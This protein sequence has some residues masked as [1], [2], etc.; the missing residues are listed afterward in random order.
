MPLKKRSKK[1]SEHLILGGSLLIVLTAIAL[2]VDNFGAISNPTTEVV[3]GSSLFGT[4]TLEYIVLFCLSLFFAFLLGYIKS[5]TG[6]GKG[7]GRIRFREIRKIIELGGDKF[8]RFATLILL[9]LALL[10]LSRLSS[11]ILVFFIE[12]HISAQKKLSVLLLLILIPSIIFV[13]QPLRRI[14]E[15]IRELHGWIGITACFLPIFVLATVGISTLYTFEKISGPESSVHYLILT[16]TLV[17]FSGI[18]LHT[19]LRVKTQSLLYLGILSGIFLLLARVPGPLGDL[20]YFE[21]FPKL[22]AFA[23]N[24]WGYLPWIDLQLNHGLYHDFIRPVFGTLLFGDSI[25]AMQA[26][27]ASILFPLEVILVLYLTGKIL[28]ARFHTVY[29]FMVFIAFT[30]AVP[31]EGQNSW[32][33]IYSLPR[34]IPLLLCTL[35]LK[36]LLQDLKLVNYAFVSVSLALSTMWASE[37][38]IIWISV[39]ITLLYYTASTKKLNLAMVLKLMFSVILIPSLLIWIPLKSL[40]L[41]QGFLGDYEGLSSNLLQGALDF[42]FKAGLPYSVFTLGLPVCFIFLTYRYAARLK[43]TLT[44]TEIILVPTLAAGIYYY[45]KFLAWPDLHIQQAVNAL[46]L[47]WF[48]LAI[49]SINRLERIPHLFSFARLGSLALIG[50]MLISNSYPGRSLTPKIIESP[51]PVFGSTSVEL[52]KNLQKYSSLREA[53]V[54]ITNSPKPIVL[55]FTNAPVY[56]HL[57]SNLRFV[58]DLS[59]TSFYVS[60]IQQKR[61]L[62]KIKIN[63]PNAIIFYSPVGL[64]NGVFPGDIFQRNYVIAGEILGQFK[65][66]TRFNDHIILTKAPPNLSENNFADLMPKSYRNC[67]WHNSLNYVP[68]LDARKSTTDLKRFELEDIVFSGVQAS[69][70]R[71]LQVKVAGPGNYSLSLLSNI[72][73]RKIVT[74]SFNATAQ[75]LT[76]IYVPVDVCPGWSLNS[77]PMGNLVINGLDSEIRGVYL[78]SVRR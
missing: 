57:Y 44:S 72:E 22:N 2:L 48:F 34:A 10:T 78:K 56:I 26:G 40:G 64:S 41:V 28:D 9:L 76:D 43:G 13:F 32:F 4:R 70:I 17:I 65:R 66:I 25:W 62:E 20:N 15:K 36:C 46:H 49:K 74:V 6:W 63:Q 42:N 14:F 3:G 16:S 71:G 67:E 61:A 38:L 21:D 8:P 24:S 35:A 29:L 51:D 11:L 69:E 68:K 18:S 31:A 39:L 12:G 50:A 73:N 5:L 23:F 47:F 60:E 55:D 59:F 45:I 75:N 54:K 53:I 58:P 7:V 1:A 33:F 30:R 52:K 77:E 27:I 19:A 37:N